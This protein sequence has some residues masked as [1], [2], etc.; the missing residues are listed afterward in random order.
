MSAL[1]SYTYFQISGFSVLE[2]NSEILSKSFIIFPFSILFETCIGVWLLLKFAIAETQ[3]D[4][5]SRC[6]LILTLVLVPVLQ[7]NVSFQ[8]TCTSK[9]YNQGFRKFQKIVIFGRNPVVFFLHK[10][11]K[12]CFS[13]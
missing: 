12:N 4:G 3:V 11:L 2:I 13:A 6:T 1:P 5:P 7:I 10:K 8:Y 9:G